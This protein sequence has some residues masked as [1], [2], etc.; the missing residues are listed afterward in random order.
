M[1]MLC[2][3]ISASAYDF[4]VDGIAYDILSFTELT[5]QV[6]KKTYSGDIIIPA[7]VAYNGKTLQVV[8]LADN[9]FRG[10]ENL[11]SVLLPNTI[12]VLGDGC[13][14]SCKALNNITLPQK[15]ERIG[16]YCFTW[17]TSLTSISLP[18]T[19]TRIGESTFQGCTAL[20]SIDLPEAVTVGIGCFGDCD[21]LKTLPRISNLCWPSFLFNRCEG[22][23]VVEIPE[24][25]LELG[26]FCFNQCKNLCDITVPSSLISVGKGCFSSTA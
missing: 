8:S 20:E 18:S 25:V 6:A 7:E 14:Y 11:L 19:L 23:E 24:G 13:F 26:D 5:C 21:S 22:L 15:L 2:L 4:E 10:C 3:S 1:A 17:C 12:T 9:C 16:D